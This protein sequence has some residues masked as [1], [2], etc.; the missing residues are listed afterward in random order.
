MISAMT[1]RRQTGSGMIPD[2]VGRCRPKSDFLSSHLVWARKM[3]FYLF[4]YFE[5]K[6][7]AA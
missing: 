4:Q 3:L 2:R 5:Y 6:E 1:T 7:N